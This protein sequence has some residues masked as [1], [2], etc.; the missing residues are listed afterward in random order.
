MEAEQ[1]HDRA[2]DEI[3]LGPVRLEQL[4]QRGGAGAERDEHGREA[5]RETE[6][7][8]KRPQARAHRDAVGE[9]ID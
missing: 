1:R 5:G 6:A 4:P 8:S 7:Q 9:F 2:G 3:G